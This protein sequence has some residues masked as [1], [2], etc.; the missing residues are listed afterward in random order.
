MTLTLDKRAADEGQQA[1]LLFKEARQRRR[2]RRA[3][4][5]GVAVAVVT[6]GL[7][8]TVEDR[9]PMN[10]AVRSNRSPVTPTALAVSRTGA[11]LVTAYNSLRVVDADS[12][13]TRTV[14]LPAPA[15]GASDLSMTKIGRSLILNRGGTAWLYGPGLD[16][17]PLDLG[18]SLRVIPGPVDGQVW[19]WSNPCAE[20]ACSDAAK[21]AS[22]GTVRL[23]D[24]AGRQIGS[25]VPLPVDANWFPTGQSLSAGLV[26]A[27]AYGPGPPGQSEIWQPTSNHVFRTLPSE[28]LAA[29]GDWI[30]TE[31]AKSCPS[32]CSI[33]ITDIRSGQVE[34]IPF[35]RRTY[36]SGVSGEGAVSPDGTRL[37]LVGTLNGSQR[38]PSAVIVVDLAMRTS[39]VLRN[40]NAALRSAYGDPSISWSSDGWLFA[41]R[42]GGSDVLA[43]RSGLRGMAVLPK[44]KLPVLH[45]SPPQYQTEDPTMLAL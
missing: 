39:Q 27:V 36:V 1:Q 17:T 7:A 38:Q 12:G 23:V 25:P 13:T 18:P 42:I 33:Q 4:G 26:L 6:A 40:S 45:L 24:S 29:H 22:N 8:V 10:P 35:P 41:T 37:A 30:A 19:I 2:R 43:W 11:T 15:G 14:P 31:S 16:G 34:V 3:I 9:S 20:T 5:V 21:N 32:D 28:P 44:V